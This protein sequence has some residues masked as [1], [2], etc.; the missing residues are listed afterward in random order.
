MTKGTRRRDR[1]NTGGAPVPLEGVRPAPAWTL[2]LRALDQ[3]HGLELHKQGL[4][5]V[6]FLGRGL[7]KAHGL[8]EALGIAGLPSLDQ[9]KRLASDGRQRV[10]TAAGVVVH[11]HTIRP[12]LNREMI[13][14]GTTEVDLS[15]SQG[16]RKAGP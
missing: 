16:H 1:R 7:D 3:T 2:P 6:Q 15:L 5:H 10:E 13:G 14:P 4:Q 11:D 12:M 9:A 8:G